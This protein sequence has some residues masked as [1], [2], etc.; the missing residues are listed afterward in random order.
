MECHA[1]LCCNLRG[2]TRARQAQQAGAGRGRGKQAAARGLQAGASKRAAARLLQA[3][4]RV[5]GQGGLMKAQHQAQL[6]APHLAVHQGEAYGQR[7]PRQ[8]TLVASRQDG[9]VQNGRQVRRRQELRR[10][11][12]L[13]HQA[14]QQ[15]QVQQTVCL[16][17]LYRNGDDRRLWKNYET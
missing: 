7:R 6:G 12:L 4:A 10:Q 1:A 16:L 3:G 2:R 14:R 11:L 8:E 9:T 15:L 13:K 5:A 17:R